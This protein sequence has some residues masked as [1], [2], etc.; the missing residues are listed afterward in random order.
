[1][2]LRSDSFSFV[3]VASRVSKARMWERASDNS[4]W[5]F[6][7]FYGIFSNWADFEGITRRLIFSAFSEFSKLAKNFLGI[8]YLSRI[9]PKR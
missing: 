8:Y 6:C 7:F 9:L 3:N 4:K 5:V 1:M 2:P